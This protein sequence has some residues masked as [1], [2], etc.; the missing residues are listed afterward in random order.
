MRMSRLRLIILLL[1][2][3]TLVVYLPVSHYG[4]SLYDDN[5]YVTENP[6]VQNGL[7]WSGIR[8][9]FTTCYA[10]NWHPVTWMSHMLDYQL[11]YL[12]PGVPHDVNVLFHVANT[13]LLLA[14]LLR[15]TR[16]IWPSAF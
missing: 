15:L 7:T 3:G 13:L 4:F 2:L 16:A 12:N 8:W 11:F 10:S 6:V 9:A 14:L 1:V 5:Y